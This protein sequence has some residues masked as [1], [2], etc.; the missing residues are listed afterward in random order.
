MPDH[1]Q[2]SLYQGGQSA[3]PSA[4]FSSS[5]WFTQATICLP[6]PQLHSFWAVSLTF[7]PCNDKSDRQDVLQSR[8][9]VQATAVSLAHIISI[10]EDK[11]AVL[12]QKV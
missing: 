9:S 6:N 2:P 8:N 5:I 7:F 11:G 10:P 1:P 3:K 12:L 4:K